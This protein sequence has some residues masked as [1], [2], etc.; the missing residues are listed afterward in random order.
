MGCVWGMGYEGYS[1]GWVQMLEGRIFP[2]KGKGSFSAGGKEN[3]YT[4]G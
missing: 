1:L 4:L 2:A 3:I